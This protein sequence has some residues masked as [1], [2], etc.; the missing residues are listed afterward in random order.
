MNQ[1]R[2]RVAVVFGGRSTEHGVSCV[3]AGSVLRHL[4]QER[5]EVVPVGITTDG[6]WVLGSAEALALS[7][8]EMPEVGKGA[9]LTLVNHDLV[10]LEPGR[11]GEALAQVDVVFPVLHGAYG[12]DGTI[13][14]LLELADIPYVGPGVLASAVAMDKE[15]TKKLLAAEG[16]P[17]CAYAVIKRGQTTLPQAERDRLGLPVFVKPARAGSSSGISK[18]TSWDDLDAAIEFARAVDPKVLVEAAVVGREVECGVLEF[19]DGRVEASVPAEIRMVSDKIDWYDF[20][21][22]YLDTEEACEFDIPAKLD[23]E[24]AARLRQMA[25]RAFTALDCQGLARV[26]FFVTPDDQ[27]VINE[28]NTMPG[29]TPVSMYPRM[30]ATTGVD[31]PTLLSTLIE[32]A[33]A[34]GTGLR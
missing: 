22:K 4:D 24:L 30:W 25:V 12:E 7:G 20:D 6:A 3:S 11:G 32:T 33:I 8:R 5:Y 31:Y 1:P 17:N 2:I 26:D 34:R 23:D 21:S 29:F 16:L 18:V 14:G 13:Q 19:P 10:T 28:V 9:E 27:L 15:Y